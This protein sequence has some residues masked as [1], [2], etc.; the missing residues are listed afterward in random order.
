[1]RR[2]SGLRVADALA[3]M[4]RHSI[5]FPSIAAAIA[6]T[7]LFACAVADETDDDDAWS[8]TGKS[9]EPSLGGVTPTFASNAL[10]LDGFHKLLDTPTGECV[11]PSAAA[12]PYSVGAIEKPF[13]LH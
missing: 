3:I 1:M 8:Q 11:T 7:S 4:K 5:S 10:L 6:F 12:T 9:D 2:E 13:D